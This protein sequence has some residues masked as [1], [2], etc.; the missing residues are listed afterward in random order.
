VGAGTTDITA[1]QAGSVG[2]FPAAD[3]V[4]TLTVN[5]AALAIKVRDTVRNFGTANPAFTITYTGF[6]LGETAA[7][8]TTQVN[9]ATTAVIN[10]APGYYTL[11]PQSATSSN[12]AIT[13]STGTL[14]ILPATG[15]DKAYM[16][17]F[18]S[19]STTLTV[20]LYSPTPVLADIVLYDMEGRYVERKNVFIPVGFTNAN[21]DVSALPRGA[22]MIKVIGSGIDLGRKTFI[23]K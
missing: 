23:S 17:A 11:T 10:S 16:N 14:T 13:Y 21:L 12:Y 4:R 8:L 22:Y 20:R 6:V 15:T 7:N 19:N 3:V 1:S 9:V 5:K 18:M 2:Y